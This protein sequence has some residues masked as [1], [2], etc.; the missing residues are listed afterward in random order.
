M[1]QVGEVSESKAKEIYV[2]DGKKEIAS[3]IHKSLSSTRF[4]SQCRS[5]VRLPW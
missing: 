1:A 4:S 2:E 3:F 5:K